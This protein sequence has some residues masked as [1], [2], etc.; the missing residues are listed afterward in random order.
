MEAAQRELYSNW[1]R[2]VNMTAEEIEAFLEEPEGQVAGLSRQEARSQGIRSG[3]DSARRI[4]KMK[5]KPVEEW[6]MT[7]WDWAQR[8]VAF[9]R[10]MSGM[11]G[12]LYDSRGAPTRKLLAL[13]V[14]GHMPS[15]IKHKISGRV[16]VRPG[17]R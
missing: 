12:S 17:A 9:I 1:K 2:L 3:Q 7:D 11:Q 15:E 4:I 14:W 6:T 16:T 8:Q 5:R 10:R 13:M